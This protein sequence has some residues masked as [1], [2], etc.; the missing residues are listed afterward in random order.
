[1]AAS[2]IQAVR[3]RRNRKTGHMAITF[4]VDAQTWANMRGKAIAGSHFGTLDFVAG[5][6]N[7]AFLECFPDFAGTEVPVPPKPGDSDDDI[8]F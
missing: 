4:E 1:M 2:M 5:A 3:K 6:L 8:P 7:M